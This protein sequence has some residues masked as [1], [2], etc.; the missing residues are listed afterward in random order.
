VQARPIFPCAADLKTVPFV[1][2][3]IMPWRLGIIVNKAIDKCLQQHSIVAQILKA[4]RSP[5]KP[6]AK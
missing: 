5:A 1:N 4:G 2:Y 6:I 3:N